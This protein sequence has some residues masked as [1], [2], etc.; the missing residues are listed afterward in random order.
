FG[1][2]PIVSDVIT[3]D[4]EGK[5]ESIIES[6]E[7]KNVIS[8]LR[9]FEF[10]GGQIRFKLAIINNTN[11]P[12]TEFIITFEIPDALKWIIHEPGYERKGDSI[13]IPKLGA[14]EK[15]SISLYLEPISCMESPINAT[16]SFHDAKDVPRALRMKPK[17][18]AISCPLY[19]TKKEVNFARVKSLKK[20]LTHHDKKTFPVINPE[21]LDVIFESVVDILGSRDIKI[22]SK[23]LS[24]KNKYGEAWFYGTTKAGKKGHVM[25]ITI[26]GEKRILELESS[27]D[28]EDQITG[29]LADVSREAREKLLNQNLI[30]SENQFFDLRVSIASHL[31]PYCFDYI[32]QNLV[33]KFT[34]GESINC[35]N[36][37]VRIDVIKP[38]S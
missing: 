10:I 27:G 2:E 14:N 35:N 36:C 19:F 13:F 38:I 29:F 32:S 20:N 33:K 11:Y 23:T 3:E 31:C 15:K 30:S 22:V 12:T 37:D 1:I 21:N 8:T 7:R 26:D 9:E 4:Q 17:T 18:I 25:R 24:V 28:D 5:V 16:I 6:V 34:N